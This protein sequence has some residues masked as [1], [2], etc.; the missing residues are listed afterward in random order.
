MTESDPEE[1]DASG[2]ESPNDTLWDL[3]PHTHGK[4]LVLRNYLNAWLPIMA[5][6]NQR[7]LFIDGFAGPGRYRNGEDGSPVLAIKAFLEHYYRPNMQ[8][9]VAFFFVEN[10]PA[11][12]RHLRQELAPLMAQLGPQAIAEVREGKFDETMTEVL[13][14][15]DEA[16]RQLAPAFVMVD[17]FG[18]SDTPMVVLERILRSDKS[19]LYVSF[20]WEFMNRFQA[21]GEFPPHLDALFGTPAWRQA[22]QMQN[23]RD[24]KNAVFNLYRDQL[25]RAGA[26]H[27][28]RFEL[29][30]GATLKY[31][32]F[33]ATKH[34]LGCD[35]MKKAIWEVDPFGGHSFRPGDNDTLE[36]FVDVNLA[37]LKEQLRRL[38]GGTATLFERMCEWTM[39][40]ATYFHSGQLKRAL[41]ELE[42]EQLLTAA[43]TSGKPR[44]RNSFPD[45]TLVTL[46]PL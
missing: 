44:R 34:P 18:V 8:T 36:L 45:G 3:A 16:R 40:D 26:V 22:F 38:F 43:S 10:H 27:V 41:R 2:D 20:M 24:R 37:P 19:E 32:I 33:F 11:R 28:I 35:K 15:I 7:I 6:R 29:F 30:E 31:A 1:Q 39:T 23:W 5:R 17:P 14:R 4:H 21:T 9:Q 12:V 13:N 25:K 42:A 46:T